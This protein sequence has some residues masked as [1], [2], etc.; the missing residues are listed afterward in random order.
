M[1]VIQL[2]HGTGRILAEFLKNYFFLLR[3]KRDGRGA[4]VYRRI[5]SDDRSKPV[6]EFVSIQRRDTKQWALPGVRFSYIVALFTNSL[7]FKKGMVDP[8][9]S[10]SDTV[11]REFQ[12]EA[13]RGGLN[14]DCVKRLFSNG[15]KLYESYIDDPRNTD[16]AWMETIAM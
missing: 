4:I 9:E 5:N 2:L 7:S 10:I 16:N 3:W 13:A 11:R 14:E 8:G 15:Y 12:E 1:L 6:L